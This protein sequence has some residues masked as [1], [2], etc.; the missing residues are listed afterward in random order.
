MTK[1]KVLV[2]STVSDTLK[3]P[4]GLGLNEIG[5]SSQGAARI[6][7]IEGSSSNPGSLAPALYWRRFLALVFKT[8]HNIAYFSL[9]PYSNAVRSDIF[10]H[11]IL[12]EESRLV[13]AAPCRVSADVAAPLPLPAPRKPPPLSPSPLLLGDAPGAMSGFGFKGRPKR[14]VCSLHQ[15]MCLAAA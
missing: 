12:T 3:P 10:L 13:D 9:P 6:E 5:I 14:D 11:G 4:S 15:G 2:T 1:W 8:S 7:L